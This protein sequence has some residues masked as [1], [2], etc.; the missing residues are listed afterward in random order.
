VLWGETPEDRAVPPV[1]R[2]R[3]SASEVL[4]FPY[5]PGAKAINAFAGA[6]SALR[7]AP[8]LRTSSPVRYAWLPTAE[9]GPLPS[10]SLIAETDAAIPENPYGEVQIPQIPA[11]LAR[12]LGNF[13]FW[14]GNVRLM[15]A[16]ERIYASASNAGLEVLLQADTLTQNERWND[17]SAESHN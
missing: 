9:T 4:P 17:E 3:K 6:L 11:A 12:R 2:S 16:L 13:P 10:S 14:R 7:T 15:D 8:K 1:L 5:D